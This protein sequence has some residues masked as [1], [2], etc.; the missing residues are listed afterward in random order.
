M[1]DRIP[2]PDKAGRVLITPEDG[3]TPFYATIAMA[4]EPLQEGTELSSTTLLR[5]TTVARYG[6]DQETVPDDVFNALSPLARYHW[7]RRTVLLANRPHLY[8]EELSITIYSTSQDI[9]PES[10]E[11]YDSLGLDE[12]GNLVGVTPQT[13][14]LEKKYATLSAAAELIKGKYILSDGNYYYVVEA[15]PSY[16]SGDSGSRGA[17]T[18]TCNLAFVL[19]SNQ[20]GEEWETLSSLDPDA[21]PTGIAEDGYY[22]SF[23][24]KA[25]DNAIFAGL[26]VATGKYIGGTQAETV[27][28]DVGF[29]PSFLMITSDRSSQSDYYNMDQ[30]TWLAFPGCYQV[31]LRSSSN[32]SRATDIF[33]ETGFAFEAKKTNK[34]SMNA[35]GIPFHWFAIGL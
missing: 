16:I 21:Y 6:M 14:P 34:N 32:T 20:Y 27:A 15:D 1:K 9:T 5:E 26:R 17:L 19:E 7:R 30:M 11:Y 33:T 10:V 12:D 4:D 8:D 29:R 3:S 13:A 35:N 24:G 22:Y 23:F 18:A 25:M 28:V 2:S 31:I